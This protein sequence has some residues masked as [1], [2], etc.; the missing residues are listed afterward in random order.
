M[1]HDWA[2]NLI[3]SSLRWYHILDDYAITIG[4]LVFF[5]IANYI[6]AV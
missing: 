4:V 1:I 3:D 6:S 2:A 5:Y